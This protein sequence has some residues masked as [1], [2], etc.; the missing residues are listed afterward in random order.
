MFK[1][2][3]SYGAFGANTADPNRRG[4]QPRFQRPN[5]T[6]PPPMNAGKPSLP[7]A[8][9]K[10]ACSEIIAQYGGPNVPAEVTA[11]SASAFVHS[12]SNRLRGSIT[13][14]FEADAPLSEVPII[15]NPETTRPL[16]YVRTYT[17]NPKSGKRSG[18][19]LCYP[20]P[21]AD[22]G[23][24]LD[25]NPAKILPDG[26]EFDS[27]APL[28]GVHCQINSVDFST[29]YVPNGSL[30]RVVLYATWEP[31]TDINDKEL[32]ELYDLCWVETSRPLI[33][34]NDAGGGG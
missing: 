12:P 27:A 18:L 5:I 9:R 7:F 33:V 15:D 21:D 23:Y 24:T 34:E 10:H 17:K 20:A 2:G 26:F 19:Q 3:N 8:A 4:W 29:N 28:F 31:N 14:A 11:V 22:T 1:A 32:K 6:I 16:W 30:V 25:G 13:I